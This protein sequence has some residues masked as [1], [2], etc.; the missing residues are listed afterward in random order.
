PL[1]RARPPP[2]AGAAG[3]TESPPAHKSPQK[4]HAAPRPRRRPRASAPPSR[5]RMHRPRTHARAAGQSRPPGF[6][7][8]SAN[9]ETASAARLKCRA[10]FVL[11]RRRAYQRIRLPPHR[12]TP[13][14]WR[15]QSTAQNENSSGPPSPRKRQDRQSPRR[16]SHPTRPQFPAPP[17]QPRSKQSHAAFRAPR[18]IPPIAAG[19]ASAEQNAA[20]PP[21]P[22]PWPLPDKR[23]R[24][25]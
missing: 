8:E 11:P 3:G 14:P 25:S 17:K 22:A 19:R 15:P 4:S 13:P 6:P 23:K 2:P 16:H 7:P 24:T 18:A 21:D 5:D 12:R 1:H 20:P 9:P 10:R